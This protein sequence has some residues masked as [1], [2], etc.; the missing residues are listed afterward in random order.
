LVYV[1]LC[2]TG[3]DN[4]INPCGNDRRIVAFPWLLT[5]RPYISLHKKALSR[6]AYSLNSTEQLFAFLFVT[7]II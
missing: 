1:G 6:H 2:W 3:L 7:A 5:N 4:G